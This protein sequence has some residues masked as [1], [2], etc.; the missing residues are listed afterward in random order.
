MSAT[1]NKP[2]VSIVILNW[3]GLEDTKLCLEYAKKQSYKNIEIIVVDNG[4]HDNSVAYLKAAKGIK[5]VKN[6]ANRGFT[7]GHIDGLRHANGDF[8]L[9]L[10]NDA[11]MKHDLIENALRNFNDESVA[12]VGGRSYHWNKENPLLDESNSFYAYQ[13]VNAING[14]AIFYQQ[15]YGVV[16]E[17][18]NVSGSCVMI[19]RSIIEQVGYLED[20]F[21]A[22]YEECDLF[23]RVKRAGYKVLYDPSVRIWHK[24]GASS[25]RKSSTFMYYMLF[26]NRYFFAVRNFQKGYLG[27][28]LKDYT[29]QGLKSIVKS[30]I[31]RG[32]QSINKPFA[33]AFLYNTLFG[34]KSFTERRKLTKELGESRYNSQILIEQAN[35]SHIVSTNKEEEIKKAIQLSKRLRPSHELVIVTTKELTQKKETLPHNVRICVD[36]GYFQTYQENFG[37]VISRY[38]WICFTTI[39]DLSTD[40]YFENI[41]NTIPTLLLSHKQCSVLPPTQNNRFTTPLVLTHRQLFIDIYGFNSLLSLNVN[42]AILLSYARIKNALLNTIDGQDDIKI[43]LGVSDKE[44][45][46]ALSV[47]TQRHETIKSNVAH[48][49]DP[50]FKRYY[51]LEQLRII[52]MWILSPKIRLRLKLAR[53][54]NLFLF[55]L[56]LK[57]KELATEIKHMKNGMSSLAMLDTAPLEDEKKA[58]QNAYDKQSKDPSGTTVFIICRDRLSPLLQIVKWLEKAGLKKI[59]LIDN[60]ST[61]PDLVKYLEKTTYQVLDMKRNVGHTVVWQQSI[62][63]IFVPYEYYIVTDP[64]VIP[65]SLP[66]PTLERLFAIHKKYPNHLKV[67]LGLKIDDLPDGYPLKEQVIEWEK[68]FW[69]YPLEPEVYEA[70]VDTTFALYKPFVYDYIIHPSIR[71][72]EPFTARHLPWYESNAKL[73]KE[74]LYYRL[75]ADHNVNTWNK[76][77]LPERYVKELARQAKKR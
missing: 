32:D 39:A 1:T 3:N 28:F 36:R 2:L 11:V 46:L 23:A 72:G 8:I 19:R 48:F 9:L 15:D 65:T 67:G 17:V 54:R 45:H 42:L 31:R 43:I 5:L 20:R 22:Y 27:A 44:S 50:L 18:N 33:K 53:L 10:N 58:G 24:V 16:E 14:E 35:V 77:E 76:D 75:R 6:S 73:D 60:D 7:G 40:S 26:R 66:E 13:F 12:V 64:D 47:A 71:L 41:D 52:T 51:R 21:F 61:Y 38:D 25:E 55:T 69:K 57:K 59:V 49:Y 37:A 34:Y 70:G 4:S 30:I 68:Q 56:K 63:P 29:K 62:V 74:E